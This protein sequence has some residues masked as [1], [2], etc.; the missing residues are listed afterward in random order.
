MKYKKEIDKKEIDYRQDYSLNY[1]PGYKSDYRPDF[2][3]DYRLNPSSLFP[4]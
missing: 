2:S 3:P 4:L 1:R